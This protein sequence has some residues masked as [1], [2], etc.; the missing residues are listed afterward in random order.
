MS[1]KAAER[2]VRDDKACGFSHDEEIL[3]EADKAAKD[4]L[5]DKSVDII[6]LTGDAPEAMETGETASRIRM[7]PGRSTETEAVVDG[8]S[9]EGM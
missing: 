3:R 8:P 7:T 9:S 1:L 4:S 5:E 6:D 2:R